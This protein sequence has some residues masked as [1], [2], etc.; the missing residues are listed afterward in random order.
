MLRLR[1]EAEKLLASL[2]TSK[3][4]ATVKLSEAAAQCERKYTEWYKE[5]RSH[6]PQ[7]SQWES[8]FFPKAR[9]FAESVKNLT[10][11][12]ISH[13]SLEG[14]TAA[15]SRP[16]KKKKDRGKRGSKPQRSAGFS[17][18]GRLEEMRFQEEEKE[19]Y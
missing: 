2:T 13:R 12:M 6:K 15:S 3:P 19:D 1:L 5:M 17:S 11:Q 16:S 9:A 10:G 14:E 18:L 4:E 7:A 8:G